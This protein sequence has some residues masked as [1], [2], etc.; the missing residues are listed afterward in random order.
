MLEQQKEN[1]NKKQ[2]KTKNNETSYVYLKVRWH[3]FIITS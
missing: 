1:L 2:T 3:E